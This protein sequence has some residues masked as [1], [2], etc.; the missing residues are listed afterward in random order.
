M[1][2]LVLKPPRG[3]ERGVV[4]NRSLSQMGYNC[5]KTKIS[6][7]TVD[8]QP[9]GNIEYADNAA[10][11]GDTEQSYH[12]VD[13]VRRPVDRVNECVDVTPQRVLRYFSQQV[14][15]RDECARR[16]C[17]VVWSGPHQL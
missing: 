15:H 12:C 5:Y 11:P 13:V 16:V 4:F 17:M 1:S 7:F 6:P 2:I 14:P 10:Y 9:F 8:V 3:F